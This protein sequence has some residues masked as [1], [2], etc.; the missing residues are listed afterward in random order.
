MI[1]TILHRRQQPMIRFNLRDL[2]RIVSTDRCEC[3][4]C[5]RR[6]QKM[7]GRSD[8]M[9]R[10]RGV[11][12]WPQA[13]LPAIKSDE[14]TTGEWL[15]IAERNVRDGVVRDE[16]TVKVE[17]RDDAPG[18]DG[19]KEHIEKRLHSDLGL[20]LAVE[21][22]N[23]RRVDGMVEPRTRRKAE[24]DPRSPLRQ[25]VSSMRYF[26]CHS[27]FSTK[28]GL[29]H[30]S[31]EDYEQAQ[32]VFK[33][34]RT[35]ETEQEMADGFRKRNVRTI[36]D[37]YRTWRLTDEDEIRQS[38]DYVIDFARK[39]PDVVYGNWVAINPAMKDF[40]LKE[41]LRLKESNTGFYGFC[42]SQNT[43]GFPPSDPI[44]DPFYKLS[45]ESGRAGSADD[46]PD[47]HRPRAS[48]RQRDYPGGRPSAPCRQGR[49]ALSR[50]EDSRRPAGLA[51][52]GRHDRHP[53]A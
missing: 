37:I 28:A 17:V 21:L 52:A 47:R 24:A 22:V 44:W 26:D 13:C 18:W 7:L 12:I 51:L 39:Y 20:K 46:R 11:S 33:R 30:A 25:E 3:G 48:G 5:F 27:H 35:F 29:H 6:M 45:I 34:K 32:R 41:F 49:G 40:W 14:R 53:A 9:V 42:Q 1:C 50:A 38:H 8:T 4:S 43:L 15:C 19:L 36:L 2:T 16:M 10:I 31:Q 23:G